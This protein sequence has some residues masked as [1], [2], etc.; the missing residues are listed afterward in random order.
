M[1][2]TTSDAF[3]AMR[4][5]IATM[6]DWIAGLKESDIELKAGIAEL[7]ERDTERKNDLKWMNRIGSA[8]IALL[9]LPFLRDL[10]QGMF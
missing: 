7:K 6:K 8:I 3:A 10:I 4:A 2:D 1:A 9:A 5:D